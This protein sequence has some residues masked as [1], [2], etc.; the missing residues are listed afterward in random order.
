MTRGTLYRRREPRTLQKFQNEFR[1]NAC[2]VL[3]FADSSPILS[4]MYLVLLLE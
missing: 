3:K 2:A 4:Y 1:V